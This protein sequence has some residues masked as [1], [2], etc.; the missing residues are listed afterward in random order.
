MKL[1]LF[2]Y[3]KKELIHAKQSL[4]IYEFLYYSKGVAIRNTDQSVF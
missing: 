1:F 4:E 3:S 2:I